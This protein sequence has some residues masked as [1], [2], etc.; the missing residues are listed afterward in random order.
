[1]LIKLKLYKFRT[2]GLFYYIFN[3]FYI[4]IILLFLLFQTI[5]NECDRETPIKLNNDSCVMKYCTKN[6]QII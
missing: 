6:F 4:N 3:N 2:N 1:M 5:L